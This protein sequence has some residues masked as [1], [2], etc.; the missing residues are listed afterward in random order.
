MAPP[1]GL[2]RNQQDQRKDGQGPREVTVSDLQATILYLLGIDVWK[3]RLPTRGSVRAGPVG[4]AK[5]R[6]E[7]NV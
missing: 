4:D 1:V 2:G 5:V 7:L 3:F 6:K